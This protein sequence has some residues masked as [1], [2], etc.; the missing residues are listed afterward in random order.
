[1]KRAQT[2]E[3]DRITYSN[4]SKTQSSSSFFFTLLRGDW[5]KIYDNFHCLKT[6]D[7]GNVQ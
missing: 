2:S 5:Y 1:M 6:M 4:I 7:L 3:P